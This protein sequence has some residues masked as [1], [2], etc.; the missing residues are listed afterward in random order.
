MDAESAVACYG[1]SGTSF[2]LFLRGEDVPV[3]DGYTPLMLASLHNPDTAIL[4][5][6]VDHHGGQEPEHHGTKEQNRLHH[7]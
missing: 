7:L 5:W 4:S 3:Y 1:S 6:L 2:G